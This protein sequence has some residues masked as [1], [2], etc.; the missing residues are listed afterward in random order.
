MTFLDRNKEAVATFSTAAFQGKLTSVQYL[1][2]QY[3]ADVETRDNLGNTP[4]KYASTKGHLE[5][6]KYLQSTPE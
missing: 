1:V 5:I 6:V 2:E 4:I 3:H